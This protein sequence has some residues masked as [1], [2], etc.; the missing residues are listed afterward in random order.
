MIPRVEA[1]GM[2]F[3]KP[4]STPDQV[5]RRLFPDH[6]LSLRRA[7]HQKR[8]AHRVIIVGFARHRFEFGAELRELGGIVLE[9][10]NYLAE[11][12][13][14]FLL[15]YAEMRQAERRPGQRAASEC[16]IDDPPSRSRT[17]VGSPHNA[18]GAGGAVPAGGGE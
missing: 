2:L 10:C 4:V 1:E 9:R 5:R 15:R 6:A 13:D 11:R 8:H 12:A 7:R 16:E 3:G 17:V 14:C 18:G